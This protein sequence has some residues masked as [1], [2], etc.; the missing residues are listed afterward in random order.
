LNHGEENESGK[1]ECKHQASEEGKKER[2]T[3]TEM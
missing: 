1:E 3:M 2:K